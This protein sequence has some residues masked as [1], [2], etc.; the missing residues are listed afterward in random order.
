MANQMPQKIPQSNLSIKEGRLLFV[1]FVTLG[2][3]K[4]Q[5]LLLRFCHV[6]GAFGNPWMT[7]G[8]TKLVSLKFQSMVE[9]L[10]NVE[11]FFH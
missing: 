9:R 6:L 10:L 2:S 11:L 5:H 3:S 8:G 1:L 4:P 7:R